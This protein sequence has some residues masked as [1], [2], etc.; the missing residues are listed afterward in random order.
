ME[1]IILADASGASMND[2]VNADFMTDALIAIN[3]NVVGKTIK[4]AMTDTNTGTFSGRVKELNGRIKVKTGTLANTS[5]VVGYLKTNSGRDVAFAI[6]LDN[7]PACVKPKQFED[8][9]I[10]AIARQ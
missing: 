3:K 4:N 9:I 10:R 8:E 6:M 5:A 1:G 2:Y 7:I